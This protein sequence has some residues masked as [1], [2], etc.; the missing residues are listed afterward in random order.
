MSCKQ[1]MSLA[2]VRSVT[3]EKMAEYV[4]PNYIVVVPILCH[5]HFLKQASL[6]AS[7]TSPTRDHLPDNLPPSRCQPIYIFV[8]KEEGIL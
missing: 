3:T 5:L 7:H 1:T 2:A 6:L 8:V 4:L